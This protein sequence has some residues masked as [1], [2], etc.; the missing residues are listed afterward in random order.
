MRIHKGDKVKI[1]AGKD[2][3]KT[4][5]VQTVDCGKETVLVAGINMYRKHL[6]PSGKQKGGVV[7]MVRPLPVG[8]VSF[9][10]PHCGKNG[11]LNLRVV[12]GK[13][14]RFCRLCQKE[15]G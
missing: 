12:A 1:L 9:V 13:K 4:G 3:G 8:K 6:R 10:C 11:R 14:I 7:E 5:E 15:I 2:Q